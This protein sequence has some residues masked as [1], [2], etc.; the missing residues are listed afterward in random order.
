[1]ADH[2][3]LGDQGIERFL[4]QLFTGALPQPPIRDALDRICCHGI[5]LKVLSDLLSNRVDRL[6]LLWPEPA[7]C[8]G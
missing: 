8:N 2:L 3:L 7:A 5:A 6:R 4:H 1:M